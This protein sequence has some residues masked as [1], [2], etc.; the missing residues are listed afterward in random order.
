[1]KGHFFL[2]LNRDVFHDGDFAPTV[3]F[4][5]L[6]AQPAEPPAVAVA[7]AAAVPVSPAVPDAPVIA[8]KNK[9]VT[10]EWKEPKIDI[11]RGDVPIKGYTLEL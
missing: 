4:V 1:M 3:V 8:L 7:P 11:K 9:D 10:I 2:P 6:V 5:P